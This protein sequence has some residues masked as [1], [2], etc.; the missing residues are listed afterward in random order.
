MTNSTIEQ[1][2]SE[3]A[4]VQTFL[5]RFIDIPVAAL[6]DGMI[7]PKGPISD[8]REVYVGDERRIAWDTW[9][10]MDGTAVDGWVTVRRD[11]VV[12]K[13]HVQQVPVYFMGCYTGGYD[14]TAKCSGCGWTSDTTP[15]GFMA[16]RWAAEHE[17]TALAVS[18]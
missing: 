6:R 8:I 9:F 5:G 3:L 2:A 16:N 7:G 15:S 12:H 10:G 14:V 11:S 13:V 1:R 17:Q 4:A 18:R